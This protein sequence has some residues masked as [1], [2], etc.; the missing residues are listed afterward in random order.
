MLFTVIIPAYNAEKYINRSVESVLK[1]SFPD[2]EIIVV[3]D[4]SKDNTLECVK[5]I[6]DSR[7]RVINQPNQGVSVARNTGI[8]QAKGD[9]ICFLDADDEYL[10]SHLEKLSELIVK[11]QGNQFFAT[12]YCIGLMS[13]KTIMPEVKE[14]DNF[15]KNAVSA[16]IKK[17]ELI[18][19]GCVCIESSVFDTYG[20]F[21]PGI[22]LGEDTDMWKRA[23]IHTGVV[24]GDYVTVKRN[25]DGSEATKYYTRR[26]EVDP[27]NRLRGYLDDTTIPD[28]VMTS[29]LVEHE[30]TKIQ[31]VRS[32][33]VGGDKKAAG[34]ILNSVD[35]S[36]IP[37]KRMIITYVCFAIPSVLIR[38]LLRSK[39]IGMYR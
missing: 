10:P 1:Q 19:T 36:K 8:R 25:R 13:G 15:I 4:G 35:K 18:W 31:V 16:T 23:Y 11:Y 3:N 17:P 39:N 14:E 27:L 37:L 34:Q 22:K 30:L 5:V 38:I 20:M 21:E 29:L 24:Y 2:F 6:T 33:L 32:Y 12:T 7:L 28:E 9:Y 26:Y